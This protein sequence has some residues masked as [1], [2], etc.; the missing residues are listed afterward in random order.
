M[1]RLAST[2]LLGSLLLLPSAASA[3]SPASSSS[4][5]STYPMFSPRGFVLFS[6]Q[7]FQAE[8]TFEAI[9]DDASGSFRGVGADLVLARNVFV[10]IGWSRFEKTG[11]RVFLFNNTVYKLGIPLTITLRPF[12]LSGGYRLTVWPRVIPYGG[13]GVASVRYEETSDFAATGDDVS[14]SGSGVV[15]L[16]GAEVR[17]TRFIGVSA[18][19][20]YSSLADIIGTAGISKEYGE[21]NLGGTAV[22]F[23]IIIGR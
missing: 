8:Q 17:V 5:P 13:I 22:R 19:I 23:R 1:T 20:H 7:Q 9:F 21:D 18:D 11:E 4:T 3:Q 2:L 6:R 12:E 14:V 10:E 16:G 15:F